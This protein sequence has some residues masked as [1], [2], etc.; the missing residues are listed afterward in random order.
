MADTKAVSKK[1][2]KFICQLVM[3]CWPIL[4][5]LVLHETTAPHYMITTEAK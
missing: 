2:P 3:P 1:M 5:V 4:K